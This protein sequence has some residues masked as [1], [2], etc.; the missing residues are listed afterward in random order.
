MKKDKYEWT[1]GELLERA[2]ALVKTKPFKEMG[3][4][5]LELRRRGIAIQLDSI[6]IVRY[7]GG[8]NP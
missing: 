2:V 5:V 4:V 3:E 1:N 8:L 7:Y 6:G